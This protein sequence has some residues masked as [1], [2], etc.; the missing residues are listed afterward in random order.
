M[1]ADESVGEKI[2]SDQK[3]FYTAML[4][5]EKLDIHI[6]EVDYTAIGKV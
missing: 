3:A 1:V 4:P 6:E 2:D 5:S